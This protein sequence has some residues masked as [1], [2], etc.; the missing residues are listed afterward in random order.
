MTR[1][2][3]EQRLEAIAARIPSM[4]AE[5]PDRD[6]RLQVL[7]GELD[8]IEDSA[9]NGQDAAFAA[10]RIDSLLAAADACV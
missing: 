7:A 10:R 5:Y 1:I 8:L 2:E 9:G 6:E 4:R 3:I